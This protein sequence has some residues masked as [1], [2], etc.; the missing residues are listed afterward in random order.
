MILFPPG[1]GGETSKWL[2]FMINWE[3]YS[4]HFTFFPSK[5]VISVRCYNWKEQRKWLHSGVHN[6][7]ISDSDWI[8]YALISQGYL[9]FLLF[10][11]SSH[12]L[13]SFSVSVSLVSKLSLDKN[14]RQTEAHQI[15]F[16]WNI[17]LDYKVNWGIYSRYNQWLINLCGS[18][19]L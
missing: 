13:L 9:F 11:S 3:L 4:F 14:Q 18:K 10:S 17:L 5:W 12:H 15:H 1:E 16:W 6:L 19:T 8:V 2:L 7:G